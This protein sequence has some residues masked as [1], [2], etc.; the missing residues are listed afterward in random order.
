MERRL[1]RLV[2]NRSAVGT[3]LSNR[4]S[5]L[6]L[7]RQC[8]DGELQKCGVPLTWEFSFKMTVGRRFNLQLRSI[9]NR[10]VPN[11]VLV[12]GVRFGTGQFKCLIVLYPALE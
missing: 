4:I 2:V 12:Y 1:G 9:D 6:D 10:G 3:C 11:L 5:I 7:E 8:G